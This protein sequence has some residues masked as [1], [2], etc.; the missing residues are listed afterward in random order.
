MWLTD[1]LFDVLPYLCAAAALANAS[2]DFR[3]VKGSANELLQRANRP[4]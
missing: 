2:W 1:W 3:E 4:H